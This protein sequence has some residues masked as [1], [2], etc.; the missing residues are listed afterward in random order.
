MAI[1]AHAQIEVEP[2]HE[3]GE[4]SVIV[5]FV[6]KAGLQSELEAHLKRSI[7]CS[8]REPGNISFDVHRVVDEDRRY[9]LYEVWRSPDALRAHFER[10]YTKALFAAFDRTLTGPVTE[11]GLRFIGDL[12]P[13]L[14]RA[15]AVGGPE[16]NPDCR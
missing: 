5:E 16:A 11:G 6:V 4:V 15:P 2:T 1:P 7:E 13:E 8:R 12:Y 10:P 14:R 3:N 9:V